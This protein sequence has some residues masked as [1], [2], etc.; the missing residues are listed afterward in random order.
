[1]NFIIDKFKK[2]FVHEPK[3]DNLYEYIKV[4]SKTGPKGYYSYSNPKENIFFQTQK[5]T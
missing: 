4:R 3:N 5:F 1:M 2:L